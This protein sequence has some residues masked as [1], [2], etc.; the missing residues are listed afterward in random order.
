MVGIKGTAHEDQYTFMIIYRLVLIMRGVSDKICRENKNT[1][2][3]F[4]K[5]F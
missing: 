1:H 2:L 4:N 5:S 3:M